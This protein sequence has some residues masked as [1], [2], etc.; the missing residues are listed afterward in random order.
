MERQ[1]MARGI[2]NGAH[3]IA[4]FKRKEAKEK[5]MEW[6]S[7]LLEGEGGSSPTISALPYG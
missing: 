1:R 7:L 6:L 5:G 4:F 3:R 2:Q